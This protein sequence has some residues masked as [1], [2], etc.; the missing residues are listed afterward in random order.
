MSRRMTNFTKIRNYFEKSAF[1]K[2]FY[3][4]LFCNSALFYAIHCVKLVFYAM[5]N[6]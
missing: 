1:N 2:R 5:D 3:K 4:L 6:P